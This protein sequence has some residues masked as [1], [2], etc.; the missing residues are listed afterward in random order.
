MGAVA[1]AAMERMRKA[2]EKIGYCISEDER[3]SARVIGAL[4]GRSVVARGA[5]IAKVSKRTAVQVGGNRIRGFVEKTRRTR[6]ARRAARWQAL[7]RGVLRLRSG[8]VFSRSSL[9]LPLH[10]PRA[11]TITFGLILERVR[12]LMWFLAFRSVIGLV[13]ET[14]LSSLPCMQ[15]RNIEMPK[16]LLLL[17]I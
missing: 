14:T 6:S 13:L 3:Y 17:L 4:W 11:H 7:L 16:V 8:P 12:L 2:N 15:S 9:L 10:S 1:A 5:A